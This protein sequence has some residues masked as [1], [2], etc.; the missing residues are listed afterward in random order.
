MSAD[1]WIGMNQ[2][3]QA[4]LDSIDAKLASLFF[5]QEKPPP[6]NIFHHVNQFHK[7]KE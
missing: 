6:C 7:E 1:D 4:I 2:K 3:V 5:A